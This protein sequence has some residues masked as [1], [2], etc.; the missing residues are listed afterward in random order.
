MKYSVEVIGVDRI[1]TK[2]TRSG[3]KAQ[4]IRPAL[5]QAADYLMD[6]TE[7]QFDSQGRRGGGR[8]KSL[9]PK[10]LA[11]KRKITLDTRILHLNHLLR[12]SVT[13]RDAQGQILDIEP[14][15][16]RFGSS[17]RYANVHQSGYPP[18]NIPA[19]P[20]LRILATDRE[21]I[22]NI[23]RDHVMEVWRT[24]GGGNR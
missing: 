20:F 1:V 13:R 2:L 17:V 18:R 14:T 9:S 11:Q 12:R 7:K 8:W 3:R 15:S 19:R 24:G 6:I 21:R 5:N 4:D 10:W 23:M 22:R 16:L